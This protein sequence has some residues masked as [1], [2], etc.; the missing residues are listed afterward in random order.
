MLNRYFILVLT[1]CLAVHCSKNHDGL[2][3]DSSDLQGTYEDGIYHCCAFGDGTD[4]CNGYEQGMCFTYGGIYD[5]C[6]P[7]GETIS[8]KVICSLCCDGLI[9]VEDM[10]VTDE[11]FADYPK[12]CGPSDKPIDFLICLPCGN[13]TCDENEN[14]CNCPNDCGDSPDASPDDSA[15]TL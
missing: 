6:I 14:R 15:G 1:S 7:A 5:Q 2:S 3:S 8:G 11:V 10:Q 9:E 12:G 4:C 13:G